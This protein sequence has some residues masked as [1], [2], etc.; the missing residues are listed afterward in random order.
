MNKSNINVSTGI[1]AAVLFALSMVV[2][3]T[4]EADNWSNNYA[5][6]KAECDSLGG[7]ACENPILQ[8]GNPKHW[9][10]P[11]HGDDN[12]SIG[13]CSDNG[14]WCWNIQIG[15]PNHY[16]TF[17]VELYGNRARNLIAEGRIEYANMNYRG[18]MFLGV[19]SRYHNRYFECEVNVPRRQYHC[20]TAQ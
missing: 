13:G 2:L 11:N 19:Y 17:P 20:I 15:N 10:N 6:A 4:A 3:G 18:V 8:Q 1:I 7:H 9:V 12:G 14:K 16:P 5:R